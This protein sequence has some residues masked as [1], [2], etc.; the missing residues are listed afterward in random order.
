M[1][2]RLD[3]FSAAANE[4]NAFVAYAK[5]ADFGFDPG[6]THLVMIRALVSSRRTP[7]AFNQRQSSSRGS[8]SP[9]STWSAIQRD[10]SISCFEPTNRSA[11]DRL[12]EA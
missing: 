9:R 1:S 12:S 6:L 8:G 5:S 10:S 11:I 3:L 7:T 4:M 2:K